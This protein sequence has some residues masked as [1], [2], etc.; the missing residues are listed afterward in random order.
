MENRSVMMKTG[1]I[2]LMVCIAVAV[3]GLAACQKKQGQ[4]Q[5]A[6]AGNGTLTL[7]LWDTNQ[8]PGISAVIKE[9]TEQTGIKVSVEVTP[10]DQY[11][12]LLE[13]AATGGSLPDVFWMHSNQAQRYGSAG[14]LMD[15]TGRISQSSIADMANFPGELV[16]LFLMNGKQYAIPKDLDTIG[17]WYNKTYFDE[18]GLSYPD[19]NWTWD[20]LKAAARKLT[21]S[22]KGR[23]GMDFRPHDCQQGWGNYVYEN[24]GFIISED[25]KK[26]GFDDPKTIEAMEWIVS[27]AKE[28]IAPPLTITAENGGDSLLKSGVIAMS[29]FGS[30]MLSDFR[31]NEY[32]AANC[33]VA[34]LPKSPGGKRVSIYNGLGWVAAAKTPYPEEA[35]KLLEF[36][37]SEDTQRKLSERGVAISAF[38]G[39]SQPCRQL[40]RL[41]RASL[42]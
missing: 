14:M 34:V 30:W 18:A 32:V 5:G 27:F 2:F 36:L 12:T 41:Q 9:F 15:L 17:L 16:G 40:P 38:K 28:G 11:W 19:E 31:N 35:W 37:G 26:S 8:E 3:I 25:K 42:H 20:D 39:T 21:D 33:D 10:W 29:G 23:Y 6:S 24:N 7:G 22:A 1:R 13:A 4:A